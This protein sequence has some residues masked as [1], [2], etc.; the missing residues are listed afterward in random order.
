MIK[1]IRYPRYNTPNPIVTC[2]VVNLKVLKFTSVIPLSLPSHLNAD[3]DEFYVTNMFWISDS[4]LTL[5]FTA[6]S[7]T[8]ASTMLCTAPD[9]QCVEVSKSMFAIQMRLSFGPGTCFRSNF[10]FNVKTEKLRSEMMVTF[11]FSDRQKL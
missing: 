1:T 3:E 4:E 11:R 9:F 7:Q 8:M 10:L 6:R 2:F 5:T